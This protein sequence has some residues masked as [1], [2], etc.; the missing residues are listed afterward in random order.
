M[1]RPLLLLSLLALS[2]GCQSHRHD[3]GAE[4]AGSEPLS[5]TRW[6]DGYELFVEFPPP[7]P[8][9]KLGFHAHVTRL[10]DFSAV[11][12]GRF[13]VRFEQ[14]GRAVAEASVDR[15]ARPGIF[16][17]ELAAPEKGSYE[18]VMVYD[19][20]VF[21]GGAIAI[22]AEPA[23]EEAGR[24]GE[25]AFLK[26]AQWKIPFATA[27]AES[28]PLARELEL[29]ATVEPAGTDQLGIGA[30]TAGRFFS[31]EKIALA[32]GLEIKKGTLLGSIAPNVEG[33]DLPR[34]ELAVEQ[35]KIARQRVER[36]LRRVK[37][38]VDEGLLPEKRLAELESERAE[39]DA[40]LASARRRL[41]R[42]M[43]PGG[44]GGIPIRATL[45]GVVAEVLVSNGEPVEAGATLLR[46]RGARELWLR[47]RFVARPQG[48][49]E[50][51]VPVAVRAPDGELRPLDPDA[52]F[53]SREPSID[54]QSR[55]ATWIAR[56]AAGVV[57]S[58]LRVGQSAV[59]VVRVGQPKPATAVPRAAVI[60]LDTRSIVFVQTGGESF[61][62]RR[63]EL[64]RR[65]GEF[66]EILSGI[67]PGERV[68]TKGGFD[69]HLASLAGA[70]ESHRH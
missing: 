29:P 65:D 57:G 20:A 6:A 53:V 68:V 41:G 17:P 30:S 28:R 40:D 26:E 35:A 24:G 13:S 37:P 8:G 54:P 23:Q 15:P 9:A 4:P 3:H 66:F 22:P 55:V 36:E 34:L 69:V 32:A 60:E 25:I 43:S 12:E 51:A 19:Q 14:G 44:K 62:K 70:V 58:E 42:V 46:L 5:F 56:T 52:R 50:G 61:E 10:A 16:T 33:D 38:R 47:A 7:E 48:E 11:A 63:V 18:L 1:K 67:Q 49:L 21:R 64:G 59:L 31:S 45:D 39:I 27:L 2:F